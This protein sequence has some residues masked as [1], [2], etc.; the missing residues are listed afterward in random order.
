[1]RIH[2]ASGDRRLPGFIHVDRRAECKPDIVADWNALPFKDSSIALLYFC[3]GLEHIRK[4]EVL[5]VLREFRRILKPKGILRL[6]LPDFSTLAKLYVNREISLFRL[7][8]LHGRQDYDGNTHY[9]SYDFDY[10]AYFLGEAGFYNIKRWNPVEVHPPDYDDFSLA[11][12][13]GIYIS[14]NVEATCK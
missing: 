14:L 13:N 8:C 10:L 5:R 11:M 9:A 2:L 6:S 4:P 12:M 7:G 3:H 1:M